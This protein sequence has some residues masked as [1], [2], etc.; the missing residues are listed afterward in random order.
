[1]KKT[2]SG[3]S[4]K[5]GFIGDKSNLSED[6]NDL[7]LTYNT[8]QTIL[9]NIEHFPAKCLDDI[10]TIEEKNASSLPNNIDTGYFANN[11]DNQPCN[12]KEYI[13]NDNIKLKNAYNK[14]SIEYKNAQKEISE[15]KGINNRLNQDKVQLSINLK[16]SQQQLYMLLKSK[17]INQDKEN[18]NPNNVINSDLKRL[19]VESEQR[20]NLCYK[21][22]EEYITRIDD[23]EIEIEDLKMRLR[24]TIEEYE[25]ENRSLKF[26]LKSNVQNNELSNFTD[27]KIIKQNDLSPKKMSQQLYPRYKA[28]LYSSSRKFFDDHSSIE[29]I[30]IDYDHPSCQFTLNLSLDDPISNKKDKNKVYN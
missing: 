12:C 7:H 11:K 15:L 30:F 21:K 2:N 25:L 5:E 3:K 29:N 6:S 20:I 9:K 24:K 4:K 8:V 22:I 26:K 19:K 14:L 18:V 27:K 10:Y 23:Q 28:E 13:K 16:N 17:K 1:M